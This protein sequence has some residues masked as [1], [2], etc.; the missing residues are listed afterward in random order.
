MSDTEQEMEYERAS[1]YKIYY[2]KG[3]ETLRTGARHLSRVLSS[4]QRKVFYE[5]ANNHMSGAPFKNRSNKD[6][7]LKRQGGD[8]IIL[9]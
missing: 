8:Y 1:D 5:Y 2:P 7:I 4:A 3:N 6:Y 9:Q